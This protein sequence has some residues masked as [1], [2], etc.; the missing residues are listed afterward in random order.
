MK[1]NSRNPYGYPPNLA[2]N[3]GNMIQSHYNPNFKG[4]GGGMI[5]P[6]HSQ[7][8]MFPNQSM[9]GGLQGGYYP[10]GFPMNS[11]GHA[12]YGGNHGGNPGS[13]FYNIKPYQKN[14]IE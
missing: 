10:G 1:I 8:N 14:E 2:H 4:R 5:P 6:M 3:P 9:R 7:N 11:Y 12:P 13:K